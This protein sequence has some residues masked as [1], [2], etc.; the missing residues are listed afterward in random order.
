[1]STEELY[2]IRKNETILQYHSTNTCQETLADEEER[3]LSLTII[4]TISGISL[5][6]YNWEESAK[7]D[8]VNIFSGLFQ[9]ISSIFIDTLHKGNVREIVLDNATIILGRNQELHAACILVATKAT[10]A[11][12]VAFEAFSQDF[13]EQFSPYLK[14]PNKVSRFSSAAELIANHF[15]CIPAS[16]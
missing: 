9:V 6:N 10:P 1:M 7:I 4:D 15:S 12:R 13:F 3:A 16:D 5:F 11:L 8:D 14:A 2:S